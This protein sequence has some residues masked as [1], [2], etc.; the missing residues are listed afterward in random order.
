MQRKTTLPWTS[1]RT[2]IV[3]LRLLQLIQDTAISVQKKTAKQRA[4]HAE[5]VA[6]EDTDSD[7]VMIVYVIYFLLYIAF[8]YR[9]SSTQRP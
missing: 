8:D 3:H 1:R 5:V 9:Q 6:D 7:E 4:P 2:S